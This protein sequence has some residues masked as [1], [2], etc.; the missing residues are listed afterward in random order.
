M[1]FPLNE[2]KTRSYE[3]MIRRLP[4]NAIQSA[5]CVVIV[6][7]FRLHLFIQ[8]SHLFNNHVDKFLEGA[9]DW[10]ASLFPLKLREVP[11]H[12]RY[13]L[14]NTTEVR[15]LIDSGSFSCNLAVIS[16]LALDLV[17]DIFT[18]DVVL[19]KVI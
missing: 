10:V 3:I 11:V 16:V 1:R 12:G 4:C 14:R 17:D 18:E 9:L 6:S 13:L 5:F 2:V 7:H 15:T 8:S 19:L